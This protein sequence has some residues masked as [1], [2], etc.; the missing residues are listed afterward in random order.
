MPIEYLI[1][2]DEVIY[3]GSKLIEGID[4]FIKENVGKYAYRIDHK[5][6]SVAELIANKK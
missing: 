4:V 3:S 6:N 1:D 5:M 2:K